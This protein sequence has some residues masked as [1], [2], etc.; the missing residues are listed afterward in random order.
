M[1]DTVA[2]AL[3]IVS[4]FHLQEFFQKIKNSIFLVAEI[5]E[6]ALETTVSLLNASLEN[7]K[8]RTNTY[9]CFLAS[10]LTPK[11]IKLQSSCSAELFDILK[12]IGIL[13]VQ[14]ETFLNSIHSLVLSFK[15]DVF[16]TLDSFRNLLKCIHEKV[17]YR[18]AIPTDE[19]YPKFK[20]LGVLWMELQDCVYVLS[21][22]NL[23]NDHLAYFA[24]R[25][26]NYDDIVNGILPKAPEDE[27]TS[28][29]VPKEEK[30]SIPT[31]L[32]ALK[33]V[34]GI[35][36]NK[37]AFAGF[38]PWA[39]AHGILLPGKESLGIIEF[40]ESY[41]IFYSKDFAE[42]ALGQMSSVERKISNEILRH[43]E[44]RIF[45]DIQGKEGNSKT[46]K[47][48]KNEKIDQEMQT[49]L[50]PIPT[51]FDRSHISRSRDK[52][53]IC[54]STQTLRESCT[55]TVEVEDKNIQTN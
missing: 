7:I 9:F 52:K 14:H 44:I 4:D 43:P 16:R 38:C 31:H 39:L 6:K 21:E 45:W 29:N 24:D 12:E 11:G 25:T 22:V 30:L 36:K 5:V 32:K 10:C 26:N 42:V 15:F 53:V 35:P 19:I 13:S 49:E 1:L 3:S 28:K 33:L 27:A 51:F 8:K 23:M 34:E 18:T 40:R 37:I 17:K 46:E 2:R 48:I 41:Y 50:H 55:Q 20:D 47:V 54:H